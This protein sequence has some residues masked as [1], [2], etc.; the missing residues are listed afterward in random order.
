MH[1][2]KARASEEAP[3]P[4][5]ETAGGIVDNLGPRAPKIKPRKL[6]DEKEITEPRNLVDEARERIE[7]GDGYVI[8]VSLLSKETMWYQ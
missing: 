8:I 6:L 2:E 1:V 7:H 5:V 3:H 4:A